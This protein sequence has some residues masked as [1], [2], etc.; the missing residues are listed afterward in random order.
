NG[1]NQFRA[2]GVATILVHHLGKTSDDKKN[3]GHKLRGSSVLPGWYDS[4]FCL[5][6]ATYGET[7]R[8]KFELRHDETPEDVILRINGDTL[9]FEVQS[10]EAAQISLVLAAIRTLGPS[11]AETV[12]A[13]CGRTRQWASDWLNRAVDQ[14]RV[15]REGNRPIR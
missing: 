2:R 4:H 15:I 12:G 13:N 1:L 11:D 6:W 10:D 7:V 9:Q 14:G 8:L 3:V 5:E